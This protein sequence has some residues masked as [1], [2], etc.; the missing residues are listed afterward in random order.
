MSINIDELSCPFC[1]EHNQ[2]GAKLAGKCW[3]N[4]LV[5]PAGLLALLEGKY[6]NKACVC[7]QCIEA[8]N[9]SPKRFKSSLT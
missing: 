2:C 8:Y 3:C 9:E 1:K 6:V 7:K 5:V 4:D